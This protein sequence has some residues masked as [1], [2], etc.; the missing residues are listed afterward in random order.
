MENKT[1]IGLLIFFTLAFFWVASPFFSAI[2]WAVAIAVVFYPLKD[3]LAGRNYLNNSTA[4]IVTLFLCCVIFI[5]PT[6]AIFTLSI[7]EAKGF[8][9]SLDESDNSIDKLIS[10]VKDTTPQI[11]EYLQK[12]G[13]EPDEIK[14]DIRNWLESVGAFISKRSLA[15]GMSTL[16]FLIDLGVM[17][18]LT[19][20]LLKDGGKLTQTLF[21]AIP[22]GAE[23][24]VL[25]FEKFKE[26]TRSTVKGSIVVACLQGTVGGAA[27]AWLDIP[28]AA[29]WMFLMILASMIPAVGASIIWAPAAIY[30]LLTGDYSKG[31]ILT[32]I[33]VGV[34]GLIDNLLRPI[35]VG[36]DT[37][38]PDYVIF[39][40][41]IGGISLLG[42]KGF[43]VGPI[44][45]GMFYV[46]WQIFIKDFNRDDSYE[47]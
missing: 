5:I 25:L 21:K 2:L 44:I 17:L 18:Y 42:L 14:E 24:E 41:T 23:R 34:I 47:P 1:F 30:F 31:I 45:A 29:L 19:Y 35:L 11:T 43:I 13:I 15:M 37:K 28:G 16:G 33:G 36:R 46:S 3:Y 40:S 7:S 26:V 27:F 4:T 22:I 32:V 6:T 20:F 9:E 12:F 38:M 39:I 10:T 8:V